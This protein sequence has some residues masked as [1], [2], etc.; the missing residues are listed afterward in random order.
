MENRTTWIIVLLIVFGIFGCGGVFLFWELHQPMIPRTTPRISSGA[1]S[2]PSHAQGVTADVSTEALAKVDRQPSA[3]ATIVF[4]ADFSNNEG[5]DGHSNVGCDLYT[6]TMALDGTVSDVTQQTSNDTEESFPAFSADGKTVYANFNTS[7]TQG[8]IVWAT[9]AD[10]KN[11]ILETEA[12][13]VAPTPDGKHIFFTML[14]GS[15]ALMS[16]DFSSPTTL[17]NVHQVSTTGK[18]YE[19]HASSNGDIA[20]YNL[21]GGGRGS[22]TAQGGIHRPSTGTFLTSTDANGYAHCFWGFGGTSV[23]CNNT[24]VYSGIQRISFDGGVV[25][26]AVGAI[27][28]PTIAAMTALDSDYAQCVTTQ[29][30]YGSFC[31][32]THLLVTVGCGTRTSTGTDTTMSKLALLVLSSTENPTIIPLGKNLAESFGGPGTS[33]YTASCRMN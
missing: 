23:Y 33:S 21:F 32:A 1:S 14:H 4:G 19:P 18:Y 5:C 24:E 29:F 2:S 25:G 7:S 11:G 15:S 30:A 10:H 26:T 9:L 6:A 13:G 28:N 3:S 20:F 8:N 31:D 17:T 16:G 12:R 22:N 27:H